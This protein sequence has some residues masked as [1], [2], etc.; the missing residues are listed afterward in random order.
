L[1]NQEVDSTRETAYNGVYRV[2]PN[3]QVSLL[4]DSITHPNGIAFLP[5]HKTIIIANSDSDKAIWYAYD[6]STKD[7]LTNAR[8]FYNATPEAKKE[9]GGPDGFKVDTQGHVFASG[10]GG[11]W[12]FNSAAKVL[13]KIKLTEP[14]SNCALSAD[15]KTL[16]VTSKMNVLRIILRK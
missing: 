2:T 14:A 15:E 8:I 16:Y 6:I 10:P 4:T 13:G 1:P 11:I 5:G 7:L 3:G 9:H 12:I